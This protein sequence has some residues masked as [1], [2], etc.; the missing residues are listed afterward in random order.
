MEQKTII[1]S[2]VAVLLLGFFHFFFL[3]P[4][5]S[6]PVGQTVNI[7]K[8][9][10]LKKVSSVLKENKIIRSRTAFEFFVILFGGEKK[11]RPAFYNFSEELPVF[12]VAWRV[13]GG[14]FFMPPVSVTIPEG[15]DLEKIANIFEKKL[16]NFN[17]EQ[18]LVSAGDLEGYLFPDTYFFLNTDGAKE[19]IEAMSK[20]YEKKIEPFRSEIMASGRTEHQIIIMASIIEG[21]ANG[22]GDREL[23]AGILWK[24]LRLGMPLQ[25]D[26]APETYKKKGLPEK[27][28]NNPGLESIRAALNPK[29]T[30]F[31]YYLHD[32]DGQIY[33]AKT[34]AEHSANIK[35][36]LKN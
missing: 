30:P 24:R 35:K 21:E 31:L 12:A 25:A 8:G 13:G 32:E 1:Y 23:I 34:F 29:E 17:R 7:E 14:R 6:F 10:S 4:P 27:P 28:I 33:Y 19:V 15:F 22:N 9:Y 18:F 11:I 5:K 2:F 20:N 26:A 16:P 36:Y 3:S